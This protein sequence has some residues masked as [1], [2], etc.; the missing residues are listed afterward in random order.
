ML[1]LVLLLAV[2]A[3][4]AFVIIAHT[5][6]TNYPTLKKENSRAAVVGACK[7]DGEA[8]AASAEEVK[9]HEGAYPTSV[10][11][12]DLSDPLKGGLLR[13]FALSHD[14]ALPY[15]SNGTTFANTSDKVGCP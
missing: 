3:V 14:Y 5:S 6:E 1:G 11:V 7:T 15:T 10:N 4:L 13:A 8:I 9:I 2:I 12:Q